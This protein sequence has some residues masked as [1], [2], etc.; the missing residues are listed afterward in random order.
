[1]GP[2]GSTDKSYW[3]YMSHRSYSLPKPERIPSTVDAATPLH[4]ALEHSAARH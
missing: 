4:P 1:M 3:S 2:I